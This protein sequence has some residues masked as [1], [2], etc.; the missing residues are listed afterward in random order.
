M[1]LLKIELENERKNS[2][3]TSCAVG[4]EIYVLTNNQDP[5]KLK[6]VIQMFDD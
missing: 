6:A 3:I 1:V 5:E 2:K 4:N